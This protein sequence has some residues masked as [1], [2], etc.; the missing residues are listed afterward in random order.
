MN[1]TRLKKLENLSKEIVSELIFEE[2]PDIEN[3]F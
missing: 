1:N 3:N 2:F